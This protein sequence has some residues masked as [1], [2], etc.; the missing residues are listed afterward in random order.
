MRELSQQAICVRGERVCAEDALAVLAGQGAAQRLVAPF[1]G[2]LA[3]RRV[4]ERTDVMQSHANIA[5]L[6][7]PQSIAANR[8]GA[9]TPAQRSMLT[10]WVIRRSV[11]QVGIV[12]VA[13]GAAFWAASQQPA[14]RRL[15]PTF[16][17][18][19]SGAASWDLVTIGPLAI[20]LLLV[21]VLLLGSSA[22]GILRKATGLLMG[23]AEQ[24]EGVAIREF[25]PGGKVVV[26]ARLRDRADRLRTWDL[27]AVPHLTPGR[28]HF[29]YRPFRFAG[30]QCQSGISTPQSPGWLLSVERIGDIAG[31]PTAEALAL[32]RPARKDLA[33]VNSDPA[34]S[35]ALR[36]I[37][38]A[39]GF[40][41][42]ALAANRAGRLTAE[43]AQELHRCWMCTFGYG[44]L[45][46]AVFVFLGIAVDESA[47]IALIVVGGLAGGLFMILAI[48]LRRSSA[49]ELAAGAVAH[50]DGLLYVSTRT[51]S[52]E[53]STVNYFYRVQGQEFATSR[54]ASQT[55]DP[56]QTYRVYYMPKGHELLNIEPIASP[57]AGA[58]SGVPTA[59]SASE[60]PPAIAPEAVGAIV[61]E[62]VQLDQQR[63]NSGVR[64]Q[65]SMQRMALGLLGLPFMQR[66]ALGLPGQL[67]MQMLAFTGASGT[68]IMLGVLRGGMSGMLMAGLRQGLAKMPGAQPISGLGDE[69][70]AGPGF[71]VVRR[72][73][74][75]IQVAIADGRGPGGPERTAQARQLAELLLGQLP[76]A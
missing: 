32:P 18:P 42:D 12:L 39:H 76:A 17:A 1:G 50:L 11:W 15:V 69:A 29:A 31:D 64:G 62:P 24:G 5:A 6:V 21:W 51:D 4:A 56:H 70:I 26:T 55:I 14:L 68:H 22:L 16:G 33:A 58:P 2:V 59:W 66:M 54:A 25:A 45:I 61:G 49:R 35:L 40:R 75:T 28:Y 7:D 34:F 8:Q 47:Q 48:S 9:L 13:H 3:G 52:D 41:L 38:T 71:L 36:V 20:P 43:Q 10:G 46:V 74:W 60:P 73:E 27:T 53:S 72:G 44:V 63:A 19:H 30:T 65:L 57:L 67:S 37:A 23:G